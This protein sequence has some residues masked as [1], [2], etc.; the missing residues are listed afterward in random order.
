MPLLHFELCYGTELDLVKIICSYR[1]LADS[2]IHG[3]NPKSFKIDLSK[4]IFKECNFNVRFIFDTNYVSRNDIISFAQ[5][6][7]DIKACN[8]FF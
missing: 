5:E 1:R 8:S 4:K 6:E 3:E 7:M 2:D